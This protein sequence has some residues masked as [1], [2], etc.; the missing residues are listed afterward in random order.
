MTAHSPVGLAPE[1]FHVKKRTETIGTFANND[2]QHLDPTGA[3]HELFGFGLK[4]ALL[5][6]M[7]GACFDFPLQKWFDFKIPKTSINPNYIQAQLNSPEL[8]TNMNVKAIWLGVMPKEELIQRSKKGAKWEEL[9][10]TF[11]SPTQTLTVHLAPS[12]GAWLLQLL[13]KLSLSNG[14]GMTY[15]EIKENFKA[16]GLEGFELFWDNKPIT[17]LYKVGL[18]QV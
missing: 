11:Q 10:L 16:N 7:H 3:N 1:K 9:S 8:T 5:N 15:A 18:L 13:P 14:N 12:H 17:T 2:I 4:K 6:Y